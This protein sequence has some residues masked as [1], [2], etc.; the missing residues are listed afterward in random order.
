MNT[1]ITIFM[2]L[3]WILSSFFQ[4][5]N[6]PFIDNYKPQ[7]ISEVA[8]KNQKIDNQII[9]KTNDLTFYYNSYNN[10]APISERQLWL[11]KKYVIFTLINNEK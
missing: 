6:V 3:G 4:N 10:L 5:V 1:L 11:V 2:A 9:K 7:P 8:M